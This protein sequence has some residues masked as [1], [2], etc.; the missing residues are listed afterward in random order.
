ME[1]SDET[2]ENAKMNEMWNKFSAPFL[3]IEI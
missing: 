2:S 3:W 1:N